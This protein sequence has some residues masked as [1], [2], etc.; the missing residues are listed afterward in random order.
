[1]NTMMRLVC[2]AAVV[3]TMAVGGRHVAAEVADTVLVAD[4]RSADYWQRL[5]LSTLQGIANREQGRVYLVTRSSDQHWIDWYKDQYGVQTRKL[6]S[7][8]K[9][10]AALSGS[11]RGWAVVDRDAPDTAN[12]AANAAALHDVVPITGDMLRAHADVLPDKPVV[13]DLRGKFR[14]QSKAEIYRW[15]AENQWPQLNHAVVANLNVPPDVIDISGFTRSH[16]TL[17]VRI[18]DSVKSSGNGAN[19][20]ALRVLRDGEVVANVQA[21]SPDEQQLIVENQG[22]RSPGEVRQVD[23]KAYVIYRIPGVRGAD[24]LDLDITNQYIVSIAPRLEGPYEQAAKSTSNSTR[25]HMQ[26][27]IRDYVVANRGFSFMLSS[28]GEY[29]Q[30]RELK[31]EILGQM[32]QDG[33]VYGWSSLHGESEQQHVRQSSRHG[34]IVLCSN[35]ATNFSFH[36]HVGP[37]GPFRQR[38]RSGPPRA[39]DPDKVYLTFVMSDGDS[40]NFVSNLMHGQWSDEARGKIP[41]GWEM[42]PLLAN[43]A[44][45]MLD[46]FYRSAKPSETFSAAASGIGYFFPDVMPEDDL[47][48][49]LRA[50]E[51]Y[52]RHTDMRTLVLLQS[53]G[54]HPRHKVSDEINRMYA[55]ILGDVLLGVQEGYWYTAGENRIVNGLPWMP[56]RLPTL[57]NVRGDN[58]VDGLVK[59]FREVLAEKE[60]GQPLF[61][62]FHVPKAHV[63]VSQIVEALGRLDNRDRFEVLEPEAFFRAYKQAASG[64]GRH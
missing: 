38:Q 12:L 8:W 45:G 54:G 22:T 34:Q 63:T 61:V 7:A 64:G 20:R 18:E 3:M 2:L 52:L 47:A 4:L 44:P 51:P 59:H 5:T 42:Q 58:P 10:P 31:G 41:F 27:D 46:Y 26:A 39:I 60:P 40:L 62:P 1:M 49:T 6:D 19:V 11:F 56:T 55:R 15:A 50:T 14:G 24:A 43:I 28:V 36:Q 48:R 9:L 57:G 29:E 21:G 23:N 35:T 17:F 16:D 13:M 30:E 25:F 37:E 33:R 53:S 32:T